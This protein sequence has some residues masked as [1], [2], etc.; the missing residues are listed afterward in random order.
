MTNSQSLPIIEP[1]GLNLLALSFLEAS[2]LV[3]KLGW[4]PFRAQQILQWMYQHRAKDIG[5]MSNLSKKDRERLQS[6]AITGLI[7]RQVFAAQRLR[8]S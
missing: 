5:S 8:N 7:I 4:P 6:I 2:A 1:S 3:E